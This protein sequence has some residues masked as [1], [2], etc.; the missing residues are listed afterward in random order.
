MRCRS[1]PA[2]KPPLRLKDALIAEGLWSQYLE[3]AIG[4]DAEIFTKAPV[5]SSVGWGAKVGIRSDSLWN[6]PEP[7]IV[8]AVDPQGTHRRCHT[9]ERCQSA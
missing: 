7:E 8:L 2:P 9:R 1:S 6:N 4:P 3:V 5:L